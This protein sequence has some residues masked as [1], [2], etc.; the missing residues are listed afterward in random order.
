[1]SSLS[2]DTDRSAGDSSIEEI[3]SSGR[4]GGVEAKRWK[5]A[6]ATGTDGSGHDPAIHQS[7]VRGHE[8][9]DSVVAVEERVAGSGGDVRERHGTSERNRP[10]RHAVLDQHPQNGHCWW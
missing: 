4:D 9:A 8:F 10:G 1:M 7:H 3:A 6:A 5:R 2:D